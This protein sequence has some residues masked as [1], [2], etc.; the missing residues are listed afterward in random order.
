MGTPK[1]PGGPAVLPTA[2]G[3]VTNDFVNEN[4]FTNFP[5]CTIAFDKSSMHYCNRQLFY[6][7]LQLT[8]VVCCIATV[9]YSILQKQHPDHQ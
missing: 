7:P 8:A 9:E 6:A 3:A 5:V 1:R 4:S 2:H